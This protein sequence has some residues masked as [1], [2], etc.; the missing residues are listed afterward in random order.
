MLDLLFLGITAV[1]FAALAWL[2]KGAEQLRQ[3]ANDE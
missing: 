3:G 2:I 1:A